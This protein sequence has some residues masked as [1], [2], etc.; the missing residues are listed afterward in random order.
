MG[1]STQTAACIGALT[2]YAAQHFHPDRDLAVKAFCPNP[3]IKAVRALF[4]SDNA[5]QSAKAVNGNALRAQ[6]RP[7]G[8]ASRLEWQYRRIL[9][10]RGDCG[11]EGVGDIGAQRRWGGFRGL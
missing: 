10:S 3:L 11:F 2:R 9:E 6:E 5:P 7:I 4:L 1:A 8:C